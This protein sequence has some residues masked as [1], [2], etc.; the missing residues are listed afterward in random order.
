MPS[1]RARCFNRP[2]RLSSSVRV[3]RI[4]GINNAFIID[5]KNPLLLV[6]R[7]AAVAGFAITAAYGSGVAEQVSD[8][9]SC[10]NGAGPVFSPSGPNAELSGAAEGYPIAD[11][12]RAHQPGELHKIKYRVGGYSHFDEIFPMDRIKRSAAPWISMGYRARSDEISA[13]RS[14]A[15]RSS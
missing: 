15:R 10:E 8:G 4:G 11:R 9:T 3:V 1:F 2:A 14:S 7:R 13:S 12:S 6:S 5:L